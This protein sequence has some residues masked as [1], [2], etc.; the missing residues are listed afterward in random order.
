MFNK[1]FITLTLTM[2]VPNTF[3]LANPNRA[4]SNMRSDQ[5]TDYFHRGGYVTV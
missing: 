5:N 3:L 2:N 1:V 4:L